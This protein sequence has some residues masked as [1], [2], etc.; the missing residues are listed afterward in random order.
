MYVLTQATLHLNNDGITDREQR[1][2][3][4]EMRRFLSHPSTGV[5]S[6]DQMPAAW[7]TVANVMQ[8]GGSISPKSSEAEEVV[9]AWHQEIRDLALILSRQL[10]EDVTVKASRAHT[11]NPALRLKEDVDQLV[12]E[13]GLSAT[14]SV[15]NAASAIEVVVEIQ[16]R[17]IFA[18]MRVSAPADRKSTKARLNWLIRQLRTSRPD[19]V[20]VRLYWPGR[21]PSTQ[22]PLSDLRGQ[23]EMAEESG[24]VATSFEVLYVRD[25]GGR[26][27]RRKNF[28]VELEQAIPE[29]YEQVGQHLKT[30][31]P[32]APRLK[33]DKADPANV[34][35]EAL[36]D[37]AEKSASSR[38]SPTQ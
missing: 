30:W 13:Q 23:P 32:P 15:P 24:K 17:S 25:L 8:A 35:P 12:K 20:Y 11:N 4:N 33:E 2:I 14:L 26:F 9:G 16:M 10:G 31:Q 36:K 38:N 22:Y 5:K 27:N 21:A 37:D 3:L 28:I 29:F 7:S 18:S 34:S 6:F 1:I 19:G